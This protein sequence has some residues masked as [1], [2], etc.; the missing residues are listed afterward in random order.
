VPIHT[1]APERFTEL[2]QPVELHEDGEWWE[3]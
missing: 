1:Q 3:V 2:F